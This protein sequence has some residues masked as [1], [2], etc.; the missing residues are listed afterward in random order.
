MEDWSQPLSPKDIRALR[1]A[2][3]VLFRWD[4]RVSRII[5]SADIGG[6]TRYAQIEYRI[7]VPSTLHL[8][9]DDVDRPIACACVVA[10]QYRPEW[11]TIM[12]H[13]LRPGD[14]LQLEWCRGSGSPKT[15]LDQDFNARMLFAHGGVVSDFLNLKVARGEGKLRRVLTLRIDDRT[16]PNDSTARMIR[17]GD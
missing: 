1:E 16:V 15:W 14:R 3:D 2:D 5:A 11:Q 12:R 7:D 9:S 8:D 13:I 6:E 10:A 17:D 4:R